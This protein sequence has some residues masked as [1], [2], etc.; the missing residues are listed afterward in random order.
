MN[1]SSVESMRLICVILT[2]IFGLS[3]YITMVLYVM[4]DRNEFYL[5]LTLSILAAV[6]SV[7]I[8]VSTTL[9]PKKKEIID[10]YKYSITVED[11]AYDGKSM[12]VKDNTTSRM[13][14]VDSKE[15]NIVDN[16]ES[17]EITKSSYKFLFIT[18]DE[19]SV[20]ITEDMYKDIIKDK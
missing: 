16:N 18:S 3:I 14:K 19:Y 6:S 2:F 7:F 10:E 13:V 4:K 9:F 1:I 12:Y 5:F 20:C 15:L 11:I 8:L 17:A